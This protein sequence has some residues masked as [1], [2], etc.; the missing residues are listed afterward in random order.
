VVWGSML[1]N[2]EGFI[3]FNCFAMLLTQPRKY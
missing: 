2:S 3:F 1:L